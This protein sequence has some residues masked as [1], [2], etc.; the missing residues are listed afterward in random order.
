MKELTYFNF[1]KVVL[2]VLLPCFLISSPLYA[3]NYT[4]KGQ[5]KDSTNQELIGATAVL[6]NIKDSVLAFYGIT[7]STG[8]FSISKIKPG[9]YIF[10]VSYLGYTSYNEDILLDDQN[11]ERNLNT[12]TLFPEST[13]LKE[14]IVT[15]DRV[16][17]SINR[18]T[19]EYHADAFKTQENSAVEDLLKKL[20]GLE[21]EDDG[22]IK[23]KGKTVQR[24]LVDGKEFFGEDPQIATKNLPAKAVKKVQVYDKKSEMSE[25]TG[26]D[27]GERE[28][29]VNL[30][31]KDTH[32]K[33]KFGNIT[34]GYG[35]SERFQLGTNFN[36][37]S[38]KTKLSFIGAGNNINQQNFSMRDYFNFMGGLSNF[39]FGGGGR[40]VTISLDGAEGLGGGGNNKGIN[41]TWSSGINLTHTFNPKLDLTTSVFSNFLK[42]LTESDLFRQNILD[43]AQVYYSDVVTTQRNKTGNHRFN[44]DLFYRMDST[45][46][47]RWRT[48][49]NYN[50]GR[51]RNLSLTDNYYDEDQIVTSGNRLNTSTGNSSGLNTSLV[52][53]KKLNSNG[54]ALTLNGSTGYNPSESDGD[55]AAV[56]TFLEGI[57]YTLDSILQNFDQQSKGLLYN[58]RISLTLPLTSKWS[59]E[60]HAELRNSDS[61]LERK[62]FDLVYSP[63]FDSDLNELLSREYNQDQSYQTGGVTFNYKRKKWNINT[64]SDLRRTALFGQVNQL[65]KPIEQTFVNVLPFWRMNYEFSTSRSLS[66]EYNTRVNEPSLQQL[67]P[68]IDNSDPLNVYAGNSN[69]RPEYVHE[70]SLNF[71]Y[72]NQFSNINLFAFVNGSLIENS[73]VNTTTVDSLFRKFTMPVNTDRAYRLISNINFGFPLKI[74]HSRGNLTLNTAF[75]KNEVYVNN[76][77]NN[78]TSFTRGLRLNISDRNSEIFEYNWGGNVNFTQV[79]YSASENLNNSYYN[80]RLFANATLSFF[81]TWAVN[82]SF[83]YNRYVGL[84]NN[85]AITYPLWNARLS[86]YFANRKY[87]LRLSVQDILNRNTGIS[88]QTSLNYIDYEQTNVLGRY[89]L[90]SFIY[91]I[92]KF[93]RR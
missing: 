79:D 2:S 10:Q 8:T 45:Q 22:T 59:F 70:G 52:Y 78:T 24:V 66:F 84:D 57:N 23:A 51:Y 46:D 73:I 76:L 93:G 83:S 19:I 34:T 74:L 86:K 12:I 13:N 55:L 64:G 60:T 62:V 68:I 27:D 41:N 49:L 69:L 32:K 17:I 89:G 47:L 61:D 43:P 92:R 77:L 85:Q 44:S 36:A 29:T 6:L 21:V 35:S 9:A 1:W 33:G 26:I 91:S 11:Y 58:A 25:F 63:T 71:N 90:L 7:N 82:S 80:Y 88:Q 16:P 87:E 42:N 28:T 31:L 65:S 4:L 50:H 18:D 14:V 53:R 39:S 81:K 56:N 37:F 20:P 67:Q 48:S 5:V 3:Q 54:A 30:T 75:A 38:D 40:R 72:F 15:S